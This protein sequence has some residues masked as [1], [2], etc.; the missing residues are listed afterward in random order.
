MKLL[1][2]F[3]IIPFSAFCIPSTHFSEVDLINPPLLASGTH[4][5]EA[6]KRLI[7]EKSNQSNGKGKI[8]LKRVR[9]LAFLE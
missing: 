6:A 4:I 7:A 5:K 8:C 3:L 1:F 9:L 2:L